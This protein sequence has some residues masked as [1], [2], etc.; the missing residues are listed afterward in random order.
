MS[1]TPG[2]PL[3][4]AEQDRGE[5]RGTPR[6]TA[7]TQRW[8]RD[9][10]GLPKDVFPLHVLRPAAEGGRREVPR[11]SPRCGQTPPAPAASFSVL[12]GQFVSDH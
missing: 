7:R 9:T 1:L 10:P 6:C 4:C 12:L 8:N 2:C 5:R 11:C 3:A